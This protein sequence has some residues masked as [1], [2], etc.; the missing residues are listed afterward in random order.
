MTLTDTIRRWAQQHP[1]LAVSLA[2]FM[3][4]AGFA[5]ATG[6]LANFDGGVEPMGGT[7]T[8]QGP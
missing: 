5:A 1:Q 2:S 8:Q 4:I 3:V 6:D 7:T